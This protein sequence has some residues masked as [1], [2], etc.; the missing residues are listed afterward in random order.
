MKLRAHHLICMTRFRNH[1]TNS[2]GYTNEFNDN[3][4]KM[5]DNIL[6]N[7]NQVIQVKRECD[8][9]CNKC[10]HIKDDVCNKP[11]KYKISHWVKVMDN[12]TLRLLKLQPDTSHQASKLLKLTIEK[13]DNNNLKNICKGC[14]YL[15]KCLAYGINKSIQ[16]IK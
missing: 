10:P 3:F 2:E 6:E 5:Q 9:V 8:D 4:I 16:S 15:D 7:P 1:S 14:E 11:S 13:V 12:K